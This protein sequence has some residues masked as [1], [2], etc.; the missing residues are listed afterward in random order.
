MKVLFLLKIIT[1]NQKQQNYG[2]TLL[3]LLLIIICSA[4]LAY[5]ILPQ[6]VTRQNSEAVDEVARQNLLLFS[7]QHNLTP[8]QCMEKDVHNDGW[9]DCTV[10]NKNK[11]IVN[12]QCGYDQ[13]HSSCQFVPLLNNKSSDMFGNNQN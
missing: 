9:V 10:E 2:L 12:I 8:L 5:F 4:I 7:Q 11:E 1:K 3:Q 6:F 13:R